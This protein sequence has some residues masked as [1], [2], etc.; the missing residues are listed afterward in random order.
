MGQLNLKYLLILIPVAIGLSWSR[1]NPILVFLA[2]A[3]AIVPLAG[4]MGDATEALARF[5]GPTIGGLLN[6]TLANAPEII[7][8]GFALHAGLVSMVKS[9][10]TGSIIGNL[11]LGLG[12]SFFAGG[13]KHRRNQRFS[14][15]AAR[16]TTSLLTLASFGLIIPGV[17]QFSASASRSI[18]RESAVV[19]FLVY[20]AYL[21]SI[22]LSQK[23]LIG[24]ARVKEKLKDQDVRPDE[25]GDESQVGWSRNKALGILA[26]VTVGLAIMSKVMIGAIEPTAKSLHLTPRFAGVFLLALV[27]NAAEIINA[28]R[29]ARKDKMDLAVGVTAGASAQVGLLVAP[30]LV[31]LGMIIGQN[32]DLIFSPL[33]LIA[34]V[35]AIY[36]TRILTYEGE[37]SWLEGLMLIGVYILFGIGFLY[38]PNT[39]PPN[40]LV[41]SP[42]AAA[43]P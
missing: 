34:I 14:P 21:A 17:T 24:E 31:F 38:H 18:S 26:T 30:V 29:F 37:S 8:S 39:D 36:L 4:L 16:T 42:A 3:L 10:L 13:I 1:A 20:L 22:F 33:E 19:L 15:Q 11:L 28:V 41:A 5:L 27:A 9:S 23:A 43:K 7:I 25:V 32:M 2:S 40:P 6:A 35:M 12:V